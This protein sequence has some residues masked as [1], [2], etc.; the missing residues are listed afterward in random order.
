MAGQRNA[1]GASFISTWMRKH[2]RSAQ[3]GVTT[4][5]VGHA[6]IPPDLLEQIPHDQEIATV[7]AD[8]AYDTR[9]CHNVIAARGAA[10]IIPPRKN[11]RAWTPTTAGAIARN[12]AVRACRY[13]GRGLWR[14]LTGYRRRSR[15]EKKINCVKLLGQGPMAR[16]FDRQVPELQVR[17]AVLTRYTILGIP[18]TAPVG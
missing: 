2:W 18:V 3:S 15:V 4:S 9:K 17:I 5:T 7:T 11:E 10:A 8:G 16:D 13:L 12:E 1:P 14:R 6:P